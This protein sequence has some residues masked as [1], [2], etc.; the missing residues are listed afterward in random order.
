VKFG[1][2]EGQY[3]FQYRYKSLPV[4]SIMRV[5]VFVSAVFVLREPYSSEDM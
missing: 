1:D 2:V 4:T 5:A 3:T